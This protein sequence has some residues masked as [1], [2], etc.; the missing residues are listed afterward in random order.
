M[1]A[2][3]DGRTNVDEAM[4]LLKQTQRFYQRIRQ[5]II[6][7]KEQSTDILVIG[8]GHTG[9]NESNGLYTD[10]DMLRMARYE[11]PNAKIVFKSD[12]HVDWHSK[13]LL[14]F[15][16]NQIEF[17]V[18]WQFN[19]VRLLL[20]ECVYVLDHIDG[21]H[22]LLSGAKVITL[23]QPWYAGWGL[24]DDRYQTHRGALTLPNFFWATCVQYT[25][26]LDP[27]YKTPC[28]FS[29]FMDKLEKL[30]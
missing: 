8:S 11:N 20:S 17:V 3:L 18:S 12:Y 29:Q 19:P 9:L 13:Q 21:V 7:P 10:F 24:T 15:D 16:D 14:D 2:D 4:P 6:N 25:R 27:I 5:Q 26:Y 1:L 28:D 30:K 22:A 23:A